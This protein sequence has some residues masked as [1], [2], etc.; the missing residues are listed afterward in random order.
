MLKKGGYCIRVQKGKRSADRI[1]IMTSVV[2]TA[3]AIS[4]GSTVLVLK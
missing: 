4:G 1:A 2:K 3:V